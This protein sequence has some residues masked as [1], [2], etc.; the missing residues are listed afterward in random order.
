MYGY[1]EYIIAIFIV[2]VC[3]YLRICVKQRYTL[4]ELRELSPYLGPVRSDPSIFVSIASYR[5]RKC[6]M[7][8]RSLFENASDPDRI[9]VGICQQNDS[10][11]DD[12]CI[13]NNMMS[14]NIRIVRL[15]YS[16]AKGPCYARYLCSCMYRGEKYYVQIDSHTVF[17]PGWDTALHEMMKRLPAN[18]VISHYPQPID[19]ETFQTETTREH[20]V[21]IICGAHAE[22]E[23]I[24]FKGMEVSKDTIQPTIPNV[25]VGTA[26]GF[27]CMPG[28]AVQTVPFDQNL[29]MLFQGEEILYSARL[30]TNGYDF[31]PPSKNVVYHYYDRNEEP[32]FWNDIKKQPKEDPKQ[33]VMS[34]L[35]YESKY[36]NNLGLGNRRS[37]DEYWEILGYDP[38]QKTFYKNM[39]DTI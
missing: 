38:I 22:N 11:V 31:Y 18:G 27:L 14:N 39:C 5:D 26:G 6:S 12:E 37:I 13:V 7:T 9:F 19:I 17:T 35:N 34:L 20:S 30:F 2:C 16:K 3:I 4:F 28:E 25:N 10:S 1:V 32:K 8:L 15:D 36:P 33:I 23:T 29:D 24:T 21:P